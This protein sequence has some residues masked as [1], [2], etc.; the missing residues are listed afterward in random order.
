MLY[1]SA[2]KLILIGGTYEGEYSLNYVASEIARADPSYDV[3]V[4]SYAFAMRHRDE[5]NKV[6]NGNFL[7]THS[8]GAMV[9]ERGAHPAK[10]VLVSPSQP[11]PRPQMAIRALVKTFVHT[12]RTFTRG[13]RMKTF[14][15]LVS[16]IG[17]F[18]LRPISNAM[19]FLRGEI[20]RF[21]LRD[22][23]PKHPAAGSTKIILSS[24]DELIRPHENIMDELEEH[25]VEIV[26]LDAM[27]DEIFI[28]TE[29]FIKEILKR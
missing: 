2:M 1:T 9:L 27:H 21:D 3:S 20:S 28:D 14:R 17:E 11:I 22:V 24:R 15:I 5:I 26:H 18:F 25:G 12:W 13:D 7:V 29:L 16:N 8:A 6:I 4:Y 10:A 19:P 23:L